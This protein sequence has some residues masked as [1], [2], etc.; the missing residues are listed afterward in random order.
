MLPSG[1]CSYLKENHQYLFYHSLKQ[2]SQ[3]SIET[4]IGGVL[5]CHEFFSAKINIYSRHYSLF[6]GNNWDSQ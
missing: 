6:D 4:L 2:D 5:R 3:A 1:N